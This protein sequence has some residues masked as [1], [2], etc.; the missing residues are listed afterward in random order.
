MRKSLN[1]ASSFSHMLLEC[2]V[3]AVLAF[4]VSMWVSW[5]IF[6]WGLITGDEG[7]YLFQ[8]GNFLDGMVRRPVPPF[9]TL[10][11]YDMIILRPD[12]GW[13]S[14]YSPGHA[15]WLVPGLF[16]G[17]PQLMTALGASITVVGAYACGRRL[18]IPRFL[19]P[20]LFLL[21]PFFLMLHG[22]LLS[23]TSGMAFSTLMLLCY[24]LWRQE[25]KSVFALLAG[26]CWSLLFLNRTWTALLIA[27]PF[28][29]DSLVQL[30][31]DRKNIRLWVGT[32]L[33]AGTALV[34]VGLY[35]VYNYLST[36]DPRQATYLFYEASENLGFGPRR[37]QGGSQYRVEHTV[38]RGFRQLWRNVR[39][40]DRWMFGTPRYTLLLWMGLAAHGWNRRWSG[41]LLGAMVAV[42]L[43]Y[44]AFW[45]PGIPTV[46]PLYQSEIFPH[47]LLLG[48]LGLS[49]IWRRSWKHPYVRLTGF[50][51]LALLTGWQSI[52]FVRERAARIEAEFG[53][54][55]ALE[56]KISELPD[57]SLL[58][59]HGVFPADRLMRHYIG[60]NERGLDSR[61]LRIRAH[62]DE[63][64]A[65]AAAFPDRAVFV[66][67][68]QPEI[69]MEPFEQ[70]FH[71][72][73]RMGAVGR[74]A[75]GVGRVEGDY[76]VT[77][78][79]AREGFLYYGWYP[80]LP[81]G[82]YEVHFDMRWRDVPENNPLRI[83]VMRDF[84]RNTVADKDISGG[85]E[86][87]FLAFH[88]QELT[89]VEP[90]VYYGGAGSME[91]RR[92]E[93]RRLGPLE[94]SPFE[95]TEHE[96]E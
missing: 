18:K 96:T 7:S 86:T 28:G 37:V 39:N 83:E 8:A 92:I 31:R 81:P 58:F 70:V 80:F 88:L 30:G 25:Q 93:I 72:R 60:L 94:T 22:T 59:I 49:R 82:R 33:F 48:G 52:G 68:D 47:F 90:R 84:G 73:S 23:H 51:G 71:D 40:L 3:L 12:H 62:P 34:G 15:L 69:M 56:Q 85:L 26:M 91:L 4:G 75:S 78:P 89:Q 9:F 61:V 2:M 19:L 1:H 14:R 16:F 17:L 45:F 10:L 67:R 43:G 27:I 76:R 11:D 5:R 32:V 53:E 24:L 57:R 44:V 50:V 41:I 79:D 87:S 54:V 63:Q 38:Q 20:A 36:G 13:L 29:V 46:G 55:W 42:F 77:E 74:S 65:I 21:S 6:Q 35:M 95:S 64:P 66:L